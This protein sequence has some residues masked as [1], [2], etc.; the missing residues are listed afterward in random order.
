MRGYAVKHVCN[1]YARFRD[2]TYTSFNRCTNDALTCGL[3]GAQCK[4]Y[5][6]IMFSDLLVD[7]IVLT[8]WNSC[9]HRR[10][11]N[12]SE[13]INPAIRTSVRTARRYYIL[14]PTSSVPTVLGWLTFESQHYVQQRKTVFIYNTH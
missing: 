1:I 13:E 5:N 4:R 6:V 11:L 2:E 10:L 12:T 8:A 3:C 14:K 7:L 9:R